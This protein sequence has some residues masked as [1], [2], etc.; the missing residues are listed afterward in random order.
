MLMAG[1][2][3]R[4]RWWRPIYRL[5]ALPC[6]LT[7]QRVKLD[8]LNHLLPHVPPKKPPKMP[9]RFEINHAPFSISCR[10]TSAPKQINDNCRDV[11]SLL[12]EDFD[13]HEISEP[14]R[15]SPLYRAHLP[16]RCV[17]CS[18][19]I[20]HEARSVAAL[21]ICRAASRCESSGDEAAQ[22]QLS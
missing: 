18:C 17:F 16:D 4:M 8:G 3:D 9:H 12:R 11:A 5:A 15:L 22:A 6:W 7:R 21:Q 19:L 13:Y 2:G 20:A 10:V 1:R 14:R